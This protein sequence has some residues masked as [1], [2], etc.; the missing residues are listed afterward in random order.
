MN[1][2]N[3][4]KLQVDLSSTVVE[5]QGVL[6]DLMSSFDKVIQCGVRHSDSPPLQKNQ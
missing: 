1:T 3:E 2:V 4:F 6:I 5:V